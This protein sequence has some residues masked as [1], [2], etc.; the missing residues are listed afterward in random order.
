MRFEV[1]QFIEVEDKIFGPLTWRQF[2]YVGGG[3]GMAVVMFFTLPFIFFLILGLPLGLLSAALAFYPVNNRPFS[4]FLEAIINYTK[5]Q[6]LYLWKQSADVVYKRNP[7]TQTDSYRASPY[8]TPMSANLNRSK[9]KQ[10]ISSLA[11]KLELQALQK[12]E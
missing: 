7:A 10:N 1:P 9:P 11:R 6:R 8:S 4:F 5:G 2:L 3:V 12:S